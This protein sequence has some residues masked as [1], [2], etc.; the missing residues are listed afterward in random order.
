MGQQ[1][2]QEDLGRGREQ[3]ACDRG[4]QP[5]VGFDNGVWGPCGESWQPGV[6]VGSS[7]AGG[8]AAGVSS[9]GLVLAVGD[10]GLW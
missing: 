1:P 3:G 10:G 7:R 6:R 4:R 2:G 9:L 5:G 8:L